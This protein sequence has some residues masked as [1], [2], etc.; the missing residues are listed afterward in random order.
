L[1][2]ASFAETAEYL[3]WAERVL[4]MREDEIHHV[5]AGLNVPLYVTTNADS[6]MV[7]ALRY[8]CLVPRRIGPR[9]QP[10]VGTPQYTLP[11]FPDPESPIVLHLNGYDAA[12]PDVGQE[13]QRREDNEQRRHLVLSEDDYLAHFVR[14]SRDWQTTLPLN[15]LEAL[16]QHTF[17]FL[18]YSVDDWDFRVIVQ[19]LLA[20]IAGTG[21]RRR[22]VGVQL[23]VDRQPDADRIAEYLQLYLGQYNIDIYWGTSQQF[24]TELH[25]RWQEYLGAQGDGWGL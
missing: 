6:F 21:S 24:S 18:G 20:A 2:K 19:G 8:R 12:T 10:Q 4:G 9:W 14:L 7:E 22:H 16:A 23:E 25:A 17:L 13:N 3:H 1:K 5:L 11:A 15:L